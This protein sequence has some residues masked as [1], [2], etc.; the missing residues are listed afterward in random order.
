MRRPQES[1]L[2]LLRPSIPVTLQLDS[3]KAVAPLSITLKPWLC[4]ALT[5]SWALPNPDGAAAAE[6]ANP[7]VAPVMAAPSTAA[8]DNAFLIEIL[9]PGAR[10]APTKGDSDDGYSRKNSSTPAPPFA[11]APWPSPGLASRLAT[12]DFRVF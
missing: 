3:G 5:V 12:V 4:S 10:L 1:M 7:S 11:I 8:T 6:P 2:E 9:R